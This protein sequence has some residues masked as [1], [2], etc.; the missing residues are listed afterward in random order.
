[1]GWLRRHKI[2]VAN[3]ALVLVFVAGAGYLLVSIMRI[4]PVQ[5]TY[6][7]SVNMP[8]SGGLQPNNDVTLRGARV[9]TVKRIDLTERGVLA[10]VDIDKA[11]Q[12]P[13]GG[14]VAVQALS[15]AGEQYIDFRPESDD[16]PYLEDGSVVEPNHVQ[17]PVPLST[18][19][20]NASALISQ[21]DPDQFAVILNELDTALGGG[22]DA[23]KSVI[24]GVSVTMSGLD[25]LLPQTTSLITNLRTIAATT[26][27]I[28]PD[29][30]T[31]T[32]SSG[33]LFEQFAAADAE[34]RQFLDLAPGQLATLGGVVDD[35]ADPITNLVTNFV[36]IAES[37]RLRTN[38]LAVL[39]P[40][41]RD[42]SLAIGIPAWNNEFNTLMDLYPRPVCDY[43]TI[44]VSP[45]HVGDGTTRL[46]N[47]CITDDPT[48][49]IRGSANA[50]R[51]DV[52]NNGATIPPGVDP[53]ER[54]TPLPP[55]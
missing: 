22:P 1:M 14:T 43:D 31:L 9:G 16:A 29:L 18:V 46:W 3:L 42:G 7:V 23:L 11:V 52:P 38:A 47:Y 34:V 24:D 25:S 2:L 36:A 48:Q 54:S 21:V 40:S 35:T 27:H 19:L 32:N 53:D 51:P 30:Q 10:V 28:Q 6:Q 55:P 50:P 8:A 17:T 39:F 15:A 20:D 45:A 4:N 33:V 26:S 13:A 5:R 49:Q 41:L 12:I 37:A 44:P